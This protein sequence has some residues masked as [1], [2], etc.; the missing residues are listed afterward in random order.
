MLLLSSRL[1]GLRCRRGNLTSVR[2]IIMRLCIHITRV[3]SVG[4]S[5]QAKR[6]ECMAMQVQAPW[7]AVG[8]VL[9]KSR[10][11]ILQHLTCTRRIVRTAAEWMCP[12]SVHLVHPQCECLCCSYR[13][14]AV[15]LPRV[16]CSLVGL[17]NLFSHFNNSFLFFFFLGLLCLGS[18]RW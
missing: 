15:R 4:C 2:F 8:V 12:S 3:D 10:L 9:L 6:V 1:V 11:P 13:Q 17:L 18:K 16:G 5:V 7:A 14:E